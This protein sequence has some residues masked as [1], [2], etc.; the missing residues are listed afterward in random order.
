M[1]KGVTELWYKPCPTTPLSYLIATSIAFHSAIVYSR[2]EI[3]LWSVGSC[4]WVRKEPVVDDTE[5]LRQL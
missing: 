5:L 1:D 3:W 2:P 4:G